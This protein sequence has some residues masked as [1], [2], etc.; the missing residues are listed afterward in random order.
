MALPTL[1]ETDVLNLVPGIGEVSAPCRGGQKLVFRCKISGQFYALKIMLTNPSV[2]QPVSGDQT[3]EVFDEITARA[4]REVQ[5]I[6][7]CDSP[8]LVRLGPLQLTHAHLRNQ[9]VVYFTEEWIK[10]QDLRTILAQSG[11]L[12][13]PEVVQLAEHIT[14]AIKTL[15]SHKAI[16]RDVKP[17]NIMRRTPQSGQATFVLLDMGLVFDMDDISLTIPGLVPGTMLYFS[18]EQTQFQ[19]KRQMDFRSDLFSLGIVLYEA[20]TAHHPFWASGMSSRDAVIGMLSNNPEHP[21]RHR[22]DIPLELEEIILRLLAKQPH[23]RYR[24]CDDLLRALARV[25]I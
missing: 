5:I 16:H 24:T 3:M 14:S 4:R 22:S 12:P 23:L 13:I 2:A 18:P 19:K 1:N 10:G 6:G 25:P 7:A 8:Y 17:G 11:P 9:D 15:W 21:T 20:A